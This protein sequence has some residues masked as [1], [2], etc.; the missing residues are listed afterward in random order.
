MAARQRPSAAPLPAS[1]WQD[2][3]VEVSHLQRH[4]WSNREGVRAAG[5]AEALRQ[6]ETAYLGKLRTLLRL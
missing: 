5:R 4:R 2:A 3:D 1:H 6:P